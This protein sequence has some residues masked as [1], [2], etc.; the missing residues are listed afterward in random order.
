MRI[1]KIFSLVLICISLASCDLFID[2]KQEEEAVIPLTV[3]NTWIL[4]HAYRIDYKL[5]GD[6]LTMDTVYMEGQRFDT[7]SVTRD[8]LIDGE[9]WF[10]LETI[11]ELG[12]AFSH[13][14]FGGGRW[15]A[16][17]N[18]GLYEYTTSPQLLYATNTAPLEPFIDTREVVASLLDPTS[19]YPLPDRGPVDTRAYLRTFRYV[20]YPEKND[21]DHR[22]AG[23]LNPTQNETDFLSPELGIVALDVPFATYS[24]ERGWIPFSKRHWILVSFDGE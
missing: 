12:K 18:D 23:P 10:R 21:N 17:R 16:N 20:E 19:T 6:E 9:R 15:L 5:S 14:A 24:E 1:V 2:N 3:G 8:T 7:L 13:C 11:S 22:V 4:E